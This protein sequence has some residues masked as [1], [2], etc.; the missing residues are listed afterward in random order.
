[1]V[2]LKKTFEDAAAEM[3]DKLIAAVVGIDDRAEYDS[4]ERDSEII[5]QVWAWDEAA[6]MIDYEYDSGFG[7]AD[8]HA[9]IAWGEKFVY[10]VHEY[11]G[12]TGIQKVPRNPM[13]CSPYWADV[14]K[15]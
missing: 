3:G 10:F 14:S 12:A 13:P 5:R 15:V 8:C 6:K 2:N 9:V 11:D 7:G 4:P 1:M